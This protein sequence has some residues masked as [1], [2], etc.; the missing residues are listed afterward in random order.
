MGSKW[1]KAIVVKKPNGLIQPA[2][3][4][5][6]RQTQ[7][8]MC[9][10]LYAD[11]MADSYYT[12]GTA[13]SV[14]LMNETKTLPSYNFQRGSI[15]EIE[16]L[17]SEYWNEKG[18][19][20]RRIGCASC[21]Y[22]CHRF[23]QIDDGPY[24]GTYSAGPEYETVSALGSGPAIPNIGAVHRA[25]E[26]CND[27]GLD[28]IS[29]DGAIQWAMETF[30]RGLLSRD[31]IDGIDLHFGSEQAITKLPRM[32]AYREGIGD[33]LADGTKRA[34]EKIGGESWKWAI[35]ARGLEQSRVETRGAMG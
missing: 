13:A 24:K 7:I 21:I 17:T 28:T 31:Q 29:T 6:F 33:L 30:E 14:G 12:Y 25:N 22:S 9:N 32:I 11:S 23:L 15:D 35:Q 4:G 2:D 3:P 20:K 8:E 18:L 16:Q 26:L 19:L 1:L 10:A 27:L 5:A 34:A